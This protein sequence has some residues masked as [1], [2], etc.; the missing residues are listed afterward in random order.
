MAV[1]R[2]FH[3]NNVSALTVEQNL[4]RDL[5]KEAIQIY[6]HDVYYVDRTTVAVD[7]LLGEDS[8]SKFTTQHPIE[9]Y[10][11]DAEGGFQGEK[12]IMSQFGLENRNEITFVVSKQRFQ[13]MD[14]Q[15]TLED[16]TGTTGGS[17]LLEAGSIPRSSLSAVLDTPTKSFIEL[18]GTDSSSTNAGDQIIQENDD[19]SFILSEESGTEFYLLTDTA[20]T[21]ADRP[22]EGDLVYHPILSR[23][24][25]ISFV[26]HD[27]PFYQLDNNPVYK[28]RCKQ[29]EYSHEEIDIGITTIDEIEGDLQQDALE[30]QFTL[31]QSSAVNEDIRIFHSITDQGLLLLDGTDSSSTDANDNVIM[32]NDSTSVGE[33][34]LLEG[35]GSDTEDASYLIQED[36]VTG[37]YTSAGSQDKTAQ[38]EL[39]DS[40]DDDVLDFSESNPFG[41]AGGT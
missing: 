34:I 21:D 30:H 9:M 18:N 8:L 14:S 27:D 20:T 37:D 36:I 31:E 33:S 6:G 19:T 24:F 16:G 11:E 5:I 22:Q 4:Y 3:T 38:N 25:E 2:A 26:D 28:L 32:E 10:I 23:M 7:S 17:V 35:G 39:F 12:E 1:N 29:Y 41:D 13:Q 15:I 40:L